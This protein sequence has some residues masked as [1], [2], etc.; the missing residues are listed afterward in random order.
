M[1]L[2]ALKP[3]LEKAAESRNPEI[4]KKADDLLDIMVAEQAQEQVAVPEVQGQGTDSA[5]QTQKKDEVD[6][7]ILPAFP[8]LAQ[9]EGVDSSF[10]KTASAYTADVTIQDL[11]KE[12]QA[13][14]DKLVKI[15]NP[16]ARIVQYG[17]VV[18]E[19]TPKVD[20]HNFEMALEHINKDLASKG[21]RA[22]GDKFQDKIKSKYIL[23]LNDRIIDGH[24][25]LALAKALGITCSLRVLDLTAMRFQEK[26]G[27]LIYMIKRSYGQDHYSRESRATTARHSRV[28]AIRRRERAR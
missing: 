15:N 22:M 24:H 23:M 10:G 2:A 28:P 1:K 21:K 14:I 11:P 20:S 8:D 12:T 6:A 13:D 19:L 17:M 25:Y 27:S 4:R 7:L 26:R 5:D 9:P 18:D 16:K 3:F